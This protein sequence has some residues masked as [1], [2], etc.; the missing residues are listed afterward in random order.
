MRSELDRQLDEQFPFAR[1][2]EKPRFRGNEKNTCLRQLN[3][4]SRA[5]RS[6][7]HRKAE[8]D[9]LHDSYRP[10]LRHLAHFDGCTQLDLVNATGLRAPTV[11]VT[12]TKMEKDGLIIRVND[13]Y[14]LR[15]RRVYITDKGKSINLNAIGAI[16]DI[17][18]KI[19]KDIPEEDAEITLR[20]LEKMFSNLKSEMSDK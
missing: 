12:L 19:M 20:T 3:G 6:I 14:D 4:I 18:S 8:G 2:A 13:D 11:S 1:D 7:M 15:A 9:N 16:A 10:F 17:E 5:F